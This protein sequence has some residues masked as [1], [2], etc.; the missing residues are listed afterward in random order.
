MTPLRDSASRVMFVPKATPLPRKLFSFIPN[1]TEPPL[2]PIPAPA[3]ISPVGF[4]STVILIIF[5]P[6]KDPSKISASTV[7]K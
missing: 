6:F 3:L 2:V 4:S 1:I 7:L 5:C